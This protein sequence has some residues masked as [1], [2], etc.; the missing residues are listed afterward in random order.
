MGIDSMWLARE[1]HESSNPEAPTSG[2][3]A[4]TMSGSNCA[5]DSDSSSSNA[6]ERLMAAE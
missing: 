3:T 2:P 5:P 6:S 4:D 1:I